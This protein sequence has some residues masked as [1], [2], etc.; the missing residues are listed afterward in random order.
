MLHSGDDSGSMEDD[1]SD[2]DSSDQDEGKSQ[3]HIPLGERTRARPHKQGTARRQLLKTASAHESLQNK[4]LNKHAPVE[5][6][7]SRRPV[8]TLRDS[9]QRKKHKPKDPRFLPHMRTDDPKE[10]DFANRYVL[11]QELFQENY[12]CW[13]GQPSC[14]ASCKTHLPLH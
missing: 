12:Q 13:C 14:K 4:R 1:S 10:Q 6:R 3:A 7:I 11:K 8:S 2:S 5:E 9:V